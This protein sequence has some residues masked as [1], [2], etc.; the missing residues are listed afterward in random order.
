MAVPRETP[1]IWTTWLPR[2]LTGE[3]S[4]EWV[5][6]FKAQHQDWTRRPPDS[7]SINKTHTG[8]I[9]APKTAEIFV[10]RTYG[11]GNTKQ[12]KRNL[13][14]AVSIKKNGLGFFLFVQAPNLIHLPSAGQS[15]FQQAFL[16]VH[17]HLNRSQVLGLPRD[18]RR[19]IEAA[20]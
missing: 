5:V 20:R 10:T 3:N 4:C 9:F 19:Q 13:L 16:T 2:L 17:E 12:L 8:P 18:H 1:Y 14:P 15:E 6:W 11:G 7:L